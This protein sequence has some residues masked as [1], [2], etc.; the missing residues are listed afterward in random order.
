MANDRVVLR[1][2]LKQMET[3]AVLITCFNRAET[4]LRCLDRLFDQTDLS[5]L[6]LDVWLVDDASP[7]CTGDKVKV[8]YDCVN[9]IRSSGGL[10]WCRGMRLAW[11][12]AVAHKDYDYYLWLNDDVI[13]NNNAV[14][15]AL[16]DSK[17]LKDE[18]IV[19]GRLTEDGTGSSAETY[20]LGGICNMNGNFVLVP[21]NVYKKL[22]FICN[23]YH[24]SYGDHDY[25][26]QAVKRGI[27]IKSA[28]II[29]GACK[30]EPRRYTRLQGKNLLQRIKTLWD[31]KGYYLPDAL[32]YKYRKTNLFGAVVSFFHILWL[33]IKG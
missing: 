21:R 32:V 15:S 7:D 12:S 26:V 25:A 23:L 13:L 20:G 22:G 2:G 30:P 31:V 5:N 27:L 18:A 28:A 4:T 33:V 11:E 10:F 9:V 16:K 1:L 17:T 6:A 3:L 24:H 14:S 19:Y 8:K 29:V